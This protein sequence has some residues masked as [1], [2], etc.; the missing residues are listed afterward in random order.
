[1]ERLNRLIG[2]ER[3]INEISHELCA[4]AGELRAPAVGALHLTCSDESERECIESFQ[5]NFARQLLPDLKFGERSV[6][7]LANLGAR[8]EWGAVHIAED[9]YSTSAANNNYKLLLVKVN[10]HV[11]VEPLSGGHRLGCMRRYDSDSAYCGALHSLMG[12]GMAPFAD[13]LNEA[14]TSDGMDRLGRLMDDGLV[15]ADERSLFA[16]LASARLQA[17]RALADIQDRKPTSPTLYIVLPCVTLNKR[18]RDGEII[19]GAYLADWRSQSPV[20]E[21]R[22]LGDDPAGYRLDRSGGG[23]TVRDEMRAEARP[24]RNQRKYILELWE[25]HGGTRPAPAA[26]LLFAEGI[27]GIHHLHRAQRIAVCNAEDHDSR[28]IISDVR[29]TLPHLPQPLRDRALKIMEY[30]RGSG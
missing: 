2:S 30:S 25:K 13:D 29:R 7:R 6:F 19:C 23:I 8:Y 1:M 9:H 24:A 27:A 4:L 22:G 18:E 15:A 26:A 28:I 5:Q 11:S 21:Y 16:A 20:C 12:G 10:A 17:R 14:L 3:E